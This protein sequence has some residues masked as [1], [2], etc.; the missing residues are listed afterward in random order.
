MIRV[1]SDEVKLHNPELVTFSDDYYHWQCVLIALITTLGNLIDIGR[2]FSKLS[3]KY[4][5]YEFT[6]EW[7][8]LQHK[9]FDIT[10]FPFVVL[11]K[12]IILVL[13]LLRLL[14]M[15]RYCF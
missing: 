5:D 12:K 13:L 7:E 15:L 14:C 4:D 11:V 10:G 1:F 8:R 2:E 9:N 6:K 3:S